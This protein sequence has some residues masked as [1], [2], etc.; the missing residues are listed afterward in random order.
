MQRLYYKQSNGYLCNRYPYD[1]VQEEGDPYIEVEESVYDETF[2]CEWG[3]SWAVINNELT[4]VDD[5]GIQNSVEYKENVRATKIMD[6]KDYLR[7]TDYVV[8]KLNELY[9]SEDPAYEATRKK[10][11]DILNERK[12]ARAE[13]NRLETLVIE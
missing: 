12:I 13:I 11:A 9:M 4:V 2:S 5:M 6:L 7:E 3:K 1:L 10:Y 8:L